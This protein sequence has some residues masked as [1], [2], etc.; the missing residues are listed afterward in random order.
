MKKVLQIK[1]NKDPK[2]HALIFDRIVIAL[3]GGTGDVETNCEFEFEWDLVNKNQLWKSGVDK[4]NDT[5]ISLLKNKLLYKLM[6]HA[7][8]CEYIETGECLAKPTKKS[9]KRK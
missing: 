5:L 1:Q 4:M 3:I 9:K 7:R 6:K 2:R 8:E